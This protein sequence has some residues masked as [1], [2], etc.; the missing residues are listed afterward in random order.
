MI[1]FSPRRGAILLCDFGPNPLDAS[2][3][4]LHRPPLSS[5]PE[6]WKVRRAIVVSPDAANH[7]HGAGPGLC[8][9]VPCS[10]TPPRSADPQDVSIPLGSYRS[11]TRDVW[12]KCSTPARVSHSRLDRVAFGGNYR[13]EFLSAADMLRVEAG[14]RTALGL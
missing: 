3:F 6:V 8:I 11:F 7:R 4:P 14:L 1:T 10:A 2:T 5:A 13:T 9:V 12:V